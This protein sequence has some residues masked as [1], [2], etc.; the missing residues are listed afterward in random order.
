MNQK[1]GNKFLLFIH[2]WSGIES[3]FAVLKDRLFLIYKPKILLI[4]NKAYSV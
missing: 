1:K 3:I 4:K 2:N